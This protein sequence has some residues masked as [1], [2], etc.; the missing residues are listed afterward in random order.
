MSYVDTDG[1]QRAAN[2][3][4]RAAE[5]AT[6]AADRIES[7]LHEF[8]TL[9]GHGYGNNIEALVELL[10]AQPEPESAEGTG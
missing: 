7:A 6:R 9:T 1:M 4:T 2:T 10:L 8:R 5:E 3:M